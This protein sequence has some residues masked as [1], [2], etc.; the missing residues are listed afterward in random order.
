MKDVDFCF[1]YILRL[2]SKVEWG[3]AVTLERYHHG[4][5]KLSYRRVFIQLR[6]K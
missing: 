4:L 6:S 5:T 1:A 3:I 2:S